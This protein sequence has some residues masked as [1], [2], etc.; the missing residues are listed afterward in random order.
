MLSKIYSRSTSAI[1]GFNVW[2]IIIMALVFTVGL[3][4]VL[5]E[6]GSIA[7]VALGD[8]VIGWYIILMI[9]SVVYMVGQFM[10]PPNGLVVSIFS[11]MTISIGC[12]CTYAGL[13]VAMENFFFTGFTGLMIFGIGSMARTIQMF[14]QLSRLS[15]IIGLTQEGYGVNR[16]GTDFND[17]SS[18]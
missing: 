6:S 4:G 7:F 9:F 16:D 15:R 18:V 3:R 8:Y 17:S 11:G 10:A 2:E 14:R 1:P 13:A 5:G 12:I